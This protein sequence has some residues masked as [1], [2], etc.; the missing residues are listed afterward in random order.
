MPE[1]FD[2]FKMERSFKRSFY[3]ICETANTELLDQVIKAN[4]NPDGELEYQVT[5]NGVP[6]CM[7]DFEKILTGIF[8]HH[9][10]LMAE[11]RGFKSIEERAQQIVKE[12]ESE[13]ENLVSDL[14]GTKNTIDDLLERAYNLRERSWK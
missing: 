2:P 4:T 6:V 8:D 11:A 9:L 7:G 13:Y 1:K 5:L 14:E 3:L 12:R 10:D